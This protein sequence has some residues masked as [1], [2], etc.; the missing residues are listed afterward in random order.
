M[1]EE[2]VKNWISRKQGFSKGAPKLKGILRACGHPDVNIF[3]IVDTGITEN[4]G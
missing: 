2:N 1:A 4:Q 3:Q